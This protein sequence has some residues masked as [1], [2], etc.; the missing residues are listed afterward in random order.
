VASSILGAVGQDVLIVPVIVLIVGLH[1]LP[2]APVFNVPLYYVTGAL[3]VLAALVTLVVVPKARTVHGVALWVVIPATC[4][5]LILWAT[6]ATVL[7]MGRNILRGGLTRRSVAAQR[8]PRACAATS[9]GR[10]RGGARPGPRATLRP[11]SATG[12]SP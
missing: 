2:L 6:A 4:S 10:E 8:P 1:F 3:L 12:R 7:A 11:R 9:L 5:A